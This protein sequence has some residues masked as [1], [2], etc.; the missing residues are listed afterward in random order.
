MERELL[1]CFGH[2]SDFQNLR[3]IVLNYEGVSFKPKLPMPESQGVNWS[4]GWNDSSSNNLVFLSLTGK[5]N[6]KISLYVLF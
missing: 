6:I 2:V 5:A 3:V 4:F 1:K